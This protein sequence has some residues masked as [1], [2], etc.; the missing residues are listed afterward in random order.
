MRET[1]QK[2]ACPNC[3]GDGMVM[4]ATTLPWGD[5]TIDQCPM[6]L[7]EGMIEVSTD[8]IAA[9]KKLAKDI[10]NEWGNK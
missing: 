2:F 5:K 4:V 7:G 3:G 9:W 1:V 8:N 6:C 10:L